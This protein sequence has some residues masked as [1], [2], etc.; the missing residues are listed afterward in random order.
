LDL[1]RGLGISPERADTLLQCK[2]G[3]RVA[4]GDLL[5]G[6]VGL[7]RRVMRA[8]QPGKIVSVGHGTI[9]LELAGQS[10]RLKAGLPGEI[11]DL[12][13]ER[14]VVIRSAGALIQGVW[15]NGRIDQGELKV[16]LE[17]PDHELTA[18]ILTDRLAGSILVS[19]YCKEQSVLTAAARLP[20]K[21]II[22]ASLHP[23][24]A[25]QAATMDFPILLIEG[26][27]Q[28]PMNPIAREILTAYVGQLAAVNAEA[29]DIFTGTKPELI[30]P[31]LISQEGGKKAAADY[32]APGKKV[33]LI[34]LTQLGRV[35]EVVDLIGDIKLP[36]R[37]TA[38]AA[39]VQLA[40]GQLVDF[41]LANLE[42]LV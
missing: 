6:P 8:P 25:I 26:F 39:R 28:H 10:K 1:T 40:N 42:I 37:L 13:S 17:N 35:G 12:I 38:S 22:L 15:G 5:A 21:G 34:G 32:F 14:G 9:L 30:V 11:V 3:D 24:L 36:N 29:E 4:K 23:A 27:G 41:P 2:V 19:G 31:N 33:R 18:D 20:L 7:T 16:V